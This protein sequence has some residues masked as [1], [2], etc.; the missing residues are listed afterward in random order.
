MMFGRTGG[1]SWAVPRGV[2]VGRVMLSKMPAVSVI[3]PV[4]N[5]ERFVREAV[6]SIL[7]QTF[8]DFELIVIDDGSSDHTPEILA[9][10]AKQDD[11]LRLITR[12]NRG[13]VASLNEGLAAA[14]APLIARMDHDDVSLPHRLAAQVRRMNHEP[15][16]VCLGGGQMM[17]DSAGRDLRVVMPPADHLEIDRRL[18]AGHGAICHPSAM[19]RRAAL[20]K[21]G[22]YRADFYPAEDLDLWLRLAEV[23]KLANLQD[24]VLRYRIHSN[25]ISESNGQKQRQKARAACEAAWARRGI[26]GTFDAEQLWRPGR[27]RLSRFGHITDFGWSAFAMGNRS[28]AFIYG[29]KAVALIPWSPQGYMLAACSIFKPRRTA[30]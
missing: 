15:E 30:S 3:L 7:S 18:L 16:L 11:R 21:A 29:L 26:A 25:S 24:V 12:P 1:I 9:A 22:H 6:A 5:G 2:L 10:L 8:N 23:G 14:R 4:F 17:I 19:I 27:G 13:L 28:T 20:D